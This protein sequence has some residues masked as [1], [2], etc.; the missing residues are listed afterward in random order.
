MHTSHAYY[1]VYKY[2]YLI[3]NIKSHTYD[4]SYNTGS[5]GAGG[6]AGV[7]VRR[8][9]STGNQVKTTGQHVREAPKLF[10]VG[11]PGTYIRE[12]PG[13]SGRR[14]ARS[15]PGWG[16]SWPPL[17][18]CATGAPVVAAGRRRVC[19]SPLQ[20]R[21]RRRRGVRRRGRD[22][23]WDGMGVG[24]RSRPVGQGALGG[25][26]HWGAT[27]V[28]VGAPALVDNGPRHNA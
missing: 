19:A 22:R 11:I 8:G 18:P 25:F 10:D 14:A 2:T 9:S 4:E 21:W 7:S 27:L 12:V 24:L 23:F 3:G 20:A 1:K 28:D 17:P 6:A 16:P 26:T 15:S 5:R 13:V